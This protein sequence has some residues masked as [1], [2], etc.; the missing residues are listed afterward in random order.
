MYMYVYIYMN[1]FICHAMLFNRYFLCVCVILGSEL[2]LKK[3]EPAVS[4]DLGVLP[5]FR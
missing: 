2:E 1:V 4:K 5:N 3:V